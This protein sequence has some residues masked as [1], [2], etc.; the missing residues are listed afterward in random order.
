MFPRRPPRVVILSQGDEVVTGQTIDTNAAWLAEHLTAL[1]FTVL[2]HVSVR[3]VTS[4]IS[5]ALLA[6]QDADVV[7]CTG[8]LG[9][10]EDDLTSAAVASASDRPLALD[11]TA[12]A[13]IRALYARFDR[14]MPAVNEKQAWLPAGCLRLDNDWGT[15]PAFAV[16]HGTSLW[17]CLPGVPHEMRA[18][19]RHRVLPL[20]TARFSLSP[21]RLVTLRTIGAG[22][23][24][25]QELLSGVDTSDAVIGT[26]AMSPEVQI[27]LRFSPETSAAR[28]LALTYAVHVA[29]GRPV[30]TI[31]GLPEGPARSLLP[32]DPGPLAAVIGAH[33]SRRGETL[34][35]AESCT[36]GV[37]AAQCTA[38]TGA[39]AWFQE[40][41]VAYANTAKTRLLGV[42][43]SLIAAHGAVSEP[44]ARAMAS[45][46][47]E[48][49]GTT[50]ALSTTGIAGPTGGRPDKPVGTVH[51]ALSGPTGDQ[52]RRLQLP[53]DRGRVQSLAA[54]AALNLLRL[55]VTS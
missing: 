9:P 42:P 31:E 24:A 48:R 6:G 54:G 29:I 46:L 8:G 34:A 16:D 39:S 41:V 23:S 5:A 10:T 20:L 17:I 30:F 1:G 36:G 53:G 32:H 51:I 7:L 18:L 47:R 50:W 13:H 38:Q 15:A 3:D 40:G 14:V 12:L 33:L 22:E 2:R 19:W 27:K 25:L 49:A 21:G 43:G 44:V 35:V 28:V 26:R 37:I 4:E 55:T 52:H 11:T 45:G